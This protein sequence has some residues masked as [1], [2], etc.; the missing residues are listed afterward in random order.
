MASVSEQGTM[1]LFLGTLAFTTM[2]NAYMYA[3]SGLS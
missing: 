1:S 2:L 3:L